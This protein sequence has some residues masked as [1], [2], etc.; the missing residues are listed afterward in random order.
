M[1]MAINAEQVI[2]IKQDAG[3]V[4]KLKPFFPT[5]TFFL[6]WHRLNPSL[7]F[8]AVLWGAKGP[9]DQVLLELCLLWASKTQGTVQVDCFNKPTLLRHNLLT[10]KFI[11][12]K[13][14]IHFDE[15][16]HPYTDFPSGSVVKESAYNAGDAQKTW[17]WSLGHED[18]LEKEMATHSSVLA[19]RIPWTEE[20]DKLQSTRS[21]RVRHDWVTKQQTTIYPFNQY[22]T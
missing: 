20:P 19:W 10:I 2:H 7:I 14:S 15:C 12:L 17:F 13:C 11:H 16:I 18:P 4:G 8:S 22:M 1:R 9:G 3:Q 21:Q 5:K 6:S